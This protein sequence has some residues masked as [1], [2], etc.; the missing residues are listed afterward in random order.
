M[1]MRAFARPP[2]R[3]MTKEWQEATNEYLKVRSKLG[4]HLVVQAL[5]MVTDPRI[6]VQKEKSNPIYGLSSEGYRGKG[7]V[8]SKPEKKQ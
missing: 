3:T 7:H 2:P 5:T 6:L 4:W 1:V 8:Q